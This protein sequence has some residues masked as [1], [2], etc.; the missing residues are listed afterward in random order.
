VYVPTTVK[1]LTKVTEPLE[2]LFKVKSFIL[3]PESAKLPKGPEPPIDRLDEELPTKKFEFGVKVPFI[4]KVKFDPI[5]RDP[6]ER[7]SVLPELICKSLFNETP[8]ALLIVK[9][10]SAGNPSPITCALAPL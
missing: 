4:V 1:L 5:V 3:G 7:I 8:A 6:D 2:L 9:L 10:T